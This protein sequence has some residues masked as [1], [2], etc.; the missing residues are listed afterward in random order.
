MNKIESLKK[1]T[2]LRNEA[3]EKMKR[4]LFLIPISSYV[5]ITAITTDYSSLETIIES[6]KENLFENF[7]I[8]SFLTI[9]VIAAYFIAYSD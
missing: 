9:S 1:E 8:F 5:L 6:L 2:E 3:K 4:R 7:K